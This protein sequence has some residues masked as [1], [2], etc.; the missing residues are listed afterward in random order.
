[1]TRFRDRE[2]V[3]VPADQWATPCYA[4]G[5]AR[6]TVTLL[7]RGAI[8]ARD[9]P[10]LLHAGCDDLVSRGE[11]A[12]RV[13]LRLGADAALVEE[14]PTAALHQAALRPLRGGLRNDRWKRLLGVE[15]LPLDDALTDCL[16][17]MKELYAEPR[18]RHR[19]RRLKSG[20]R[21]AGR[22]HGKP[23]VPAVPCPCPGKVF[24]ARS[25]NADRAALDGWWTEGR[26]T[27]R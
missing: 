12:R 2:P 25:W 22:H 26:F 19:P 5:L 13:A 4:T 14:R 1:V 11:L 23:F 16:P 3:V 15:R 10:R 21:F 17:R 8:L 20:A 6:Q 9:S 27:Q 18:P 24:D 7:E